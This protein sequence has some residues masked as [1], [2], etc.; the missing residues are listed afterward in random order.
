[1]ILTFQLKVFLFFIVYFYSCSFLVPF[2]CLWEIAQ[3]DHW[4]N[5]KENTHRK[6]MGKS[7][8]ATNLFQVISVLSL[9]HKSKNQIQLSTE[10]I[11]TTHTHTK[12]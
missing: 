9:G 4:R 7:L 1:M 12:K 2:C 3:F 11:Q 5:I 6:K 10:T 8:T